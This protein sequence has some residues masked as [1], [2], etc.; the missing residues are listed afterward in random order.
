VKDN[1]GTYQVNCD[2][3]HVNGDKFSEKIQNLC[4][5]VTKHNICDIHKVNCDTIHVNCDKFNDH[6]SKLM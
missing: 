6:V 5:S 1:S 3:I 4:K 2:T